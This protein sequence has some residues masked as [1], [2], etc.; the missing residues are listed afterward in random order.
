MSSQEPFDIRTNIPAVLDDLARVD[1]AL[2]T[3]LRRSIRDAGDAIIDHQRRILATENPGTLTKRQYTKAQPARRGGYRRGPAARALGGA[4]L[5]RID[6][7]ASTGRSK[8]ETRKTISDG[9]KTRMS[10]GKKRGASVRIATTSASPAKAFNQKIIRH[11]VFGSSSTWAAQKGLEYF[12]RG[13]S[14]GASTTRERIE[15]I[16][17]EAQANMR[18]N[19]PVS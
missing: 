7:A 16:L 17:K 13:V 11:R 6:G 19:P 15:E 3:G 18:R 14:I 5:A 2:V 9:L 8:N 4:R 12:S 1:K 10:V